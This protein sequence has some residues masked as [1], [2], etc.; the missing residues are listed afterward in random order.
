VSAQ[1]PDPQAVDALLGVLVRHAGEL[2]ARSG[3][4]RVA[5][6]DVSVEIGGP[7]PA[8]ALPVAEDGPRAL[9]VVPDG[10]GPSPS[11]PPEPAIAAG[12]GVHTV[13]SSTVGV[14]YRAPEP[15][16]APFVAEGDTVTAGQQIGIV[17]AMKL[18]IPLEADRGGRLVEVLLA[19]GD[20]V[21][22][23]QPVAT[24]ELGT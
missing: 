10:S 5:V 12:A 17:E 7:D 2:A 3:R 16:S 22:H 24:L 15:G 23:G 21:E 20:A 4:A 9:S 1:A 6:G 8:G 19:D 14:F 11:V 18:M 13:R